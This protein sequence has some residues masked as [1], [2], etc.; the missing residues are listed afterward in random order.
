[1]M[2]S[3]I[4]YVLA[5]TILAA[6]TVCAQTYS[7]LDQFGSAQGDPKQPGALFQGPDGSL[8]GTST[9][10]GA[11]GQGSYFT[12]TPSGQLQTLYS[13]CFSSK[14]AAGAYPS[15][16]MFRPDG[17]FIGFT[18]AGG[19]LGGG[20]VFDFDDIGDLTVLYNFQHPLAVSQPLIV[21]PDGQFYGI[22]NLGGLFGCGE[23]INYVNGSSGNPIQTLYNFNFN[24]PCQPTSLV[25]GT[26]GNFYGTTYFTAGRGINCG[27]FFK[28]TLGGSLSVIHTF[29]PNEGCTPASLTLGNDGNFY[30]T[31]TLNNGVFKVT[32]AG[33]VTVLQSLNKS[34]GL[35]VVPGLVQGS[36]GNFYGAASAGGSSTNWPCFGFGCGTLF[37]I[38]PAGNLTVIHDF[39]LTAGGW[40]ST[41][42][43]QHTNGLFY[44]DAAGGSGWG[45]PGGGVF[46]SLNNNLAPFAALT[47]YA[48]STG[49]P[50]EIIGQGF[51]ASTT[52]SF[53]GML[54]TSVQVSSSSHLTVT[55]PTGA[56]TG[57]V[58]VTTSTGMLNSNQPFVVLP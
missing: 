28:L 31:T 30:G 43:V 57:P 17:H 49:T 48:A 11:Y 45:N 40:P 25:V 34:E 10:G 22:A 42:P 7:V 3:R 21:G 50:I 26:D 56:T 9:S 4:F 35:F 24:G 32:P 39:D 6:T 19:T 23:I 41:P 29:E 44:G 58:T 13:F 1:M 16:L 5:L 51:T 46:Y 20:T 12:L 18:V 15:P 47:P 2:R 27:T 38:T 37:Q 52:V 55:V 8:Y 14:C 54:A 36:D 33:K 53:N